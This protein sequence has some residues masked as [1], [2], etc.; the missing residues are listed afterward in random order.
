MLK[1]FVKLTTEINVEKLKKLASGLSNPED[2]FKLRLGRD[3]H[4]QGHANAGLALSR[5]NSLLS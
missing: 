2:G 1:I 4:S 5:W 3:I